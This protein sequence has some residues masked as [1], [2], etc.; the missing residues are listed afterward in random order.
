VF[1]L[2]AVDEGKGPLVLGGNYI[3]IKNS[4]LKKLPSP[5]HL[6]DS[7][8]SINQFGDRAFVSMLKVSIQGGKVNLPPGMSP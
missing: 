7:D 5:E 3:N 4:G 1:N 6:G 2:F 8:F